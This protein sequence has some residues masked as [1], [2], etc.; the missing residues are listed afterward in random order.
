MIGVN[1]PIPVP[2]AYHSFGGWKALA[3]RRPAHARPRRRALLHARQGRHDALARSEPGRRQPRLPDPDRAANGHAFLTAPH[4]LPGKALLGPT[5]ARRGAKSW[6]PSATKLAARSGPFGH[7]RGGRR[8]GRAALPAIRAAPDREPGRRFF[9][10]RGAQASVNAF[11]NSA[12]ARRRRGPPASLWR[13]SGSRAPRPG[14]PV[15]GSPHG[16]PDDRLTLRMLSPS[17][18]S[19]MTSAASSRPHSRS[20]SRHARSGSRRSVRRGCRRACG[21]GVLELPGG[22]VA[23][24]RRSSGLMRTMSTG[25]ARRGRVREREHDQ[26]VAPRSGCRR[27]RRSR[28]QTASAY[29]ASRMPRGCPRPRRRSGT[30]WNFLTA[31]M[32]WRRR[33]RRPRHGPEAPRTVQRRRVLQR[34]AAHG[35]PAAPSSGLS[36]CSSTAAVEGAAATASAPLVRLGGPG[37]SGGRARRQP[38]LPETPRDH[39]GGALLPAHEVVDTIVHEAQAPLLNGAS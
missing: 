24:A 15:A 37:P 31:S 30:S 35:A 18:V 11:P 21:R 28:I 33:R 7:F 27:A 6:P 9:G 19:T 26:V 16:P 3:V 38:A 13:S 8:L 29:S 2:M 4:A 20:L 36:R 5:R 25:F 12:T 39:P 17:S 10:G 22:R 1:V 14:P 34:L 32:K 23:D